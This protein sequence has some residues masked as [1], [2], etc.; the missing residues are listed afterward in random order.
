MKIL[1]IILLA[2]QVFALFGTIV[3]DGLGS[4]LS[5]NIG[6]LIGYFLPGIIGIILLSKASKK[7]KQ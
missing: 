7:S 6:Y 3:G 2:L 5:G 1:G 4:L